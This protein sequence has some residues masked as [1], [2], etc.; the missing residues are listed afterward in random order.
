MIRY[1]LT[2]IITWDTWV[3]TTIQTIQTSRMTKRMRLITILGSPLALF[4]ISFVRVAFMRYRQTMTS[5]LVLSF[6][7]GAGLALALSIKSIT[8][9]LRPEGAGTSYTTM[10]FPSAH[11]MMA[12]IFFSFLIRAGP[13][14][15]TTL[16]GDILFVTACCL[17][18][19]LISGSRLYLQVHRL[20]DIVGGIVI[21]IVL[22]ELV[23]RIL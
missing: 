8:Q 18:I 10:S 13:G 14:H 22:L 4:T 19:L 1:L 9:R 15:I 21:G 11:A 23:K 16:R 2:H 3:D 20:S 7:M 5:A 6:A 12:T 17:A